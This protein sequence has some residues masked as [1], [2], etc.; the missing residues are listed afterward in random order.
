[1]KFSPISSRHLFGHEEKEQIFFN[2]YKKGKIHHAWMIYGEHG[3]GKSTYAYKLAK[4]ILTHNQATKSDNFEIDYNNQYVKQIEKLQ[5]PDFMLIDAIKNNDDTVKKNP[6]ISIE[7]IRQI[8]KFLSL[9]SA[10]SN[11]KVVIIDGIEFLSTSATNAL[12]KILEEPMDNSYLLLITNKIGIIPL[13]IKSR[14]FLLRL[15]RLSHENFIKLICN[16]I[17]DVSQD[18]AAKLSNFS[19]FDINIALSLYKKKAFTLFEDVKSALMSRNASSIEKIQN[20]IKEQPE[21]WETIKHII[22]Y[23]LYEEI[24]KKSEESSV[25]QLVKR[26]EKI[27]KVINDANFLHLDKTTVLNAIFV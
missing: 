15:K 6:T 27:I 13:T 14:C 20:N 21:N 25:I 12:L 18:E 3:I 7:E 10:N 1:M 17:P 26:L 2:S 5:H 24:Q 19:N 11:N 4:F 22:C 8:P 9:T 16:L 23:T